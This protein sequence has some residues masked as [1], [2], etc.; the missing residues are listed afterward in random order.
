MTNIYNN[1]SAIQNAISKAGGVP[2]PSDGTWS[3]SECTYGNA[4]YSRLDTS[5]GLDNNIAKTLSV[6]VRPVLEF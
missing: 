3:S 4:W 1:Q 6:Y 2:Y 5:Y